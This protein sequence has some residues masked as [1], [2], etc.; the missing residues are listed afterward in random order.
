M[1]IN[2]P[3]ILMIAV[4]VTGLVCLFD[5]VFLASR[6]KA[7]VAMVD[8]QFDGRLTEE[9]KETDEAYLKATAKARSDSPALD[10]VIEFSKSFFPVLALVFVLRS[11]LVE[12]FQIPSGSMIP[13]L[14]VGDFIVVNKFTYGIRMPV[15]RSKLLNIN[16]PKRG[17]VVVFFP[18]H[19]DRYFI[20]RL[21]GVPGDRIR[22]DQHTLYINGELVPQ[23]LLRYGAVPSCRVMEETLEGETF[24][25]QKCVSRSALLEDSWVVPEGHYFMMGDNRDNSQDS[26][27]WGPVPDSNI[28]GKAFAVWMHWDKGF[29]SFKT[30][31]FID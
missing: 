19:E 15:I 21:I 18:P 6:R 9:Q 30:A 25:T 23:K 22:Y 10:G 1:D 5:L 14:K 12:P 2:L 26:R 13:T 11:F 8:K 17:D 20:K 7:R 29:P 31:R 28:V 24:T 3:L 16:Q 4:G 27:V